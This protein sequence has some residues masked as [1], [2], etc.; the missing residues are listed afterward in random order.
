MSG[1]CM[2]RSHLGSFLEMGFWKCAQW[3]MLSLQLRVKLDGVD[4][5]ADRRTAASAIQLSS[6]IGTLAWPIC[7]LTMVRRP[8]GNR[9]AAHRRKDT[10]FKLQPFSALATRDLQI[11]VLMQTL[12]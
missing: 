2:W 5:V 9:S 10:V 8:V 7:W 3:L 1:Y 12:R 11:A 6:A 4:P